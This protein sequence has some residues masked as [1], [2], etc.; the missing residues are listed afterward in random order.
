MLT[1]SKLEKIIELEESLRAEYQAKLDAM[2]AE[3]E[4]SQQECRQLQATVET[5]R[6]AITDLSRPHRRVS[7]GQHPSSTLDTHGSIGPEAKPAVGTAVAGCC[8]DPRFFTRM[9]RRCTSLENPP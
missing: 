3:I 9:A 8:P 2:T 6:A 7:D 4:R 1:A 5:Q